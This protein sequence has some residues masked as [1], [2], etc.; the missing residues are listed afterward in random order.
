VIH[1]D[2]VSRWRSKLDQIEAAA[3]EDPE[4]TDRWAAQDQVRP[5]HCGQAQVLVA[6]FRKTRDF[7]AF[8]KGV[9]SWARHQE[10]P[11]SAFVGFGMMWFNQVAKKTPEGNIEVVSVLSEAL[12]VPADVAAASAKIDAVREVTKDLVNNGNP[13]LRRIPFILSL[14]WSTA[15]GDEIKNG[16]YDGC[17]VPE[18]EPADARKKRQIPVEGRRCLGI[19]AGEHTLPLRLLGLGICGHSCLLAATF[20]G[21]KRLYATMRGWRLRIRVVKGVFQSTPQCS[22]TRSR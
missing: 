10:G 22:N 5:D 12:L 3:A 6:G 18:Q 14:F 4:V 11:F 1:P 16:A 7:D 19:Q 9:D 8:R 20:F 13:A 21:E 15:V 17:V 2:D